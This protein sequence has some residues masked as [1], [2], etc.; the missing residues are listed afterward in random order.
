MGL[1]LIKSPIDTIKVVDKYTVKITLKEPNATFIKR[2]TAQVAPALIWNKNGTPADE[3]AKGDLVGVGP[4]KLKKFQ[5]NQ[6]VIYEATRITTPERRRWDVIELKYTNSTGLRTALEA[7]DIDIAF[8]TLNPVDIKQLKDSEDFKTQHT[9]NSPSV[10]YMLFNVTNEVFKDERVRRA[11]SYAVNRKIIKRQVFS[12]LADPIYTMVPK[13]WVGRKP[14][15]PKQN[16]NKA[17]SLLKSAGYTADNPLKTTL[18]FTPKHYG[19]TEADVATVLMGSLNKPENLDVQAKNLEWGA[20]TE[21]MANGG[22]G[23][24]LLGWY[25]DYLEASNFLEPW[26]TGSP[27]GLGTFFNHHPNYEAYK[28]ILNTAKSMPNPERRANYTKASKF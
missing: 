15:F 18:W 6:S 22:F 14:T 23:M 28:K 1:F 12:G 26:T 3:F 25:P 5:P 2:V 13:G 17:E 16:L 24:F 27:E 21:R 10:R 8:R 9:P 7:G 19:T 20:Y 4:Y 11:I